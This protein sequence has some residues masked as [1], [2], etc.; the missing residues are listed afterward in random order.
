MFACQWSFCTT[1]VSS[2][3]A[4]LAFSNLFP[5]NASTFPSSLLLSFILQ[6]GDSSNEGRVL[7]KEHDDHHQLY[8]L[9]LLLSIALAAFHLLVPHCTKLFSPAIS[10]FL[11]L[12]HSFSLS[13]PLTSSS[14]IPPSTSCWCLLIAVMLMWTD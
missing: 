14:L 3:G 5:L 9:S 11:P 10:L 4:C 8:T 6:Q 13:F 7:P 12:L 2:A 1:C